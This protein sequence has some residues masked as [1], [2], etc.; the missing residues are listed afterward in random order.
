MATIL[1]AD[2][3]P[4]FVEIMRWVLQAEGYEVITASDGESAVR[5]VRE[6][7]PDLV[8][9]DVMMA[10]VL[11]GLDA[12][13]QISE[14]TDGERIPIIMASSITGSPQAG[15]FPTDQSLPIDAWLSKPINPKDL[16]KQVARFVER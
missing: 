2:D 16:L 1:V 12:A 10:S 6:R 5:A 3:D 14:T 11:D 13:Y 7:G 15:M 8:V 9:L 4:D